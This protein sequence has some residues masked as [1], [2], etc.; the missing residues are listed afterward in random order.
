[1]SWSRFV[2]GSLLRQ[3]ALTLALVVAFVAAPVVSP[4]NPAPAPAPGKILVLYKARDA[5]HDNIVSYLTGFLGTAGYAWDA[6]DVETFLPQKPDMSPYRGIMTCYLS[7]QM[8]GAKDYSRWMARQLDEGRKV[9]IIGS[10]GAYQ[11]L[12]REKD[13]TTVEYNESTARINTF[14]WPFGLEFYFAFSNDRSRF[15]VT[16]RSKQFAEFEAPLG[17]RDINYYQLFKS[18]YADNRVYLSVERSDMLDSDSAFICHTPYGGMILE[19]YGYFWDEQRKKMVQRVDMVHFLK[20][21]FEGKAPPVAHYDLARHEQLK[22]IPLPAR[23]APT[24]GYRPRPQEVKRRV[25]VMYK[26]SEA[27]T[28]D[29]HPL[30][31]RADIVLTYLGLAVDY[32]AVEDGLPDDARMIRYRG[33]ISWNDTSFMPR[34]EAYGQWLIHQIRSGRK[35]VIFEDYGARVDQKYQSR[36]RNTREVFAALGIAW[37]DPP[38]G[39]GVAR[40]Y[41][42]RS[43]DPA[44]MAFERK[45]Q[46][47]DLTFLD[48]T[49]SKDPANRVY[50]SVQDPVAGPV[51]L[52]VTTPHGGIAMGSSPF[53]FPA[54]DPR[55]QQLVRQAIAKK[56]Q[57]ELAEETSSGNWLLNPYKFLAEALD[58]KEVPAPDYTTMNGARIFYSHIDGDAFDSISLIDDAHLASFYIIERILKTHPTIPIGASVISQ[59]VEKAGNRYYSPQVELART[60]YRLPNVEIASHGATHFFDWVGGDPVVV[61]P[62]SYP[63]QI[64]YQP[65]DLALDCW[66]T[67]LFIERNLAPPGKKC[68][69]YYWTGATN[70]DIPALEAVWRAGMHNLNGGDPIYDSEHDSIASLCPISTPGGLGSNLADSPYRQFQTSG[71]NDYLYTLF[72]TGDWAGQR[73]LLEHFRYT[74]EPYRILPMNLYF[75]Y[76]SG[77]KQV[78]VDAVRYVLESVAAMEPA[79]MWPSQ[80]LEI[81]EDFYQTNIRRVGT[82]DRPAWEVENRGSLREIRLSG[83]RTVDILASTGVVGFSHFQGNTYVHLDGRPTRRLVLGSPGAAYVERCTAFI[84]EGRLEQGG[85]RLKIRAFGPV[86]MTLAGLGRQTWM[87]RLAGKDGKTVFEQPLTP[88]E[89]GKAKAGIPLPA[90]QATYQLR[91]SRWSAGRAR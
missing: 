6:R 4:G 48:L 63:Y 2:A 64:A 10:Y 80:Y 81:A 15:R 30:Y 16:N 38:E 17:D 39:G 28:L 88:G 86:S 44:W 46:L 57:P 34:G 85:M 11:G 3:G 35:V 53:Y 29:N 33:I 40:P 52:V 55:H 69:V 1:M 61:N 25:L 75:H 22:A 5:N 8:V 51:D 9:A 59:F 19:G 83:T 54:G 56:I 82:G 31:S 32:H 71:R 87:L 79:M 45:A 90:G 18:R 67:K 65:V 27:S 58:T 13:G 91:L 12:L 47:P 73:K 62:D 68:E 24:D 50:A 77:L 74:D 89:N 23:P 37:A 21:C 42:L 43:L 41:W 14:L 66:A 84:D 49:V 20:G 36:V 60:M 72:L 78:S 7:S 76:F 70:P 26:R